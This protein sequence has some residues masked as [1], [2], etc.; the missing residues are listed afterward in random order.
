MRSANAAND[1]TKYNPKHYAYAIVR[2][3]LIFATLTWKGF[4]NARAKQ[5]IESFIQE[6]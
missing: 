3:K 5:R 1:M 2:S 4:L 6:F